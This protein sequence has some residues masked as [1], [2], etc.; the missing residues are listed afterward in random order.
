M[1][2]PPRCRPAT[3]KASGARRSQTL[4]ASLWSPRFGGSGDHVTVTIQLIDA[5]EDR[6]LWAQKYDRDLKDLLGMEGE[7]SREIAGK[8]GGTI[9]AQHIV[10]TAKSRPIDP[11]VYELC[12]LGRFHWNK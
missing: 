7:L 6:H 4:R 11:R 1:G 10:N 2:R 5:T 3:R 12:L 9:R 8:V